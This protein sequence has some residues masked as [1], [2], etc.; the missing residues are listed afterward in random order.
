M[1]NE[2]SWGDSKAVELE[3]LISDGGLEAV[4]TT[5]AVAQYQLVSPGAAEEEQL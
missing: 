4:Y 3:R 2:N 5:R 1:P